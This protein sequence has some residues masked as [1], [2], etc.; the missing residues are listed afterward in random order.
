[1]SRNVSVRNE[2]LLRNDSLIR[3]DSLVRSDS[4]LRNECLSDEM[5]CDSDT[6]MECCLGEGSALLFIHPSMGLS[7]LSRLNHFVLPTGYK[8]PPADG[9]VIR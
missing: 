4:L 2:R 6:E 9:E 7:G 5:V 8:V 3:S 1:L